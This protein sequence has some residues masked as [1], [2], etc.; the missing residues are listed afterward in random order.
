MMFSTPAVAVVAALCLDHGYTKR[1][2]SETV[3]AELQ[4]IL[5]HQHAAIDA[6]LYVYRPKGYPADREL[7]ML[8]QRSA[9]AISQ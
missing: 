8:V 2:W 3:V 5:R 9:L 7:T 4:A 6:R 1:P